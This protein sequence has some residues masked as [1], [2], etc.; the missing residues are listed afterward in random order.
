MT[1]K[2]IKNLAHLV[3]VEI[4][5]TK[6]QDAKIAAGLKKA[7]ADLAAGFHRLAR[8]GSVEEILRLERTVIRLELERDG[9]HGLKEKSLERALDG[10]NAA[11]RVLAN[12]RGN[13]DVYRMTDADHSLPANRRQDL[14]HEQASQFFSSNIAR[15]QNAL[16]D[17]TDPAYEDVLVARL[18]AM[19]VGQELYRNIQRK[20]LGR[21]TETDPL[22]KLGV[23][24]EEERGKKSLAR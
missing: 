14:P 19:K 5:L 24:T 17:R 21:E 16:K 7:R 12:A 4:S 22:R 1:D 10:V 23:P 20:A 8:Q 15:L 13:R 9:N 11:L 3:R 2:K 18:H 6:K